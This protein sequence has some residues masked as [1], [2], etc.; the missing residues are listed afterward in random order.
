M[1]MLETSANTFLPYRFAIVR[2]RF[3]ICSSIS[4][5]TATESAWEMISSPCSSI[6]PAITEVSG[7][8]EMEATTSPLLSKTA[9]QVPIPS[10]ET[11]VYF[12]LTRCLLSFSI[13]S[14]PTPSALTEVTKV[15][16]SSTFP[17]SSATF[18]LTP[19]CTC[20]TR[21]AFR[22]PGM[23]LAAGYPLMSTKTVPIIT[24]PFFIFAFSSY[25]LQKASMARIR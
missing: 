22:P 3:R 12:M 5:S 19:P 2:T 9:S 23:Y 1:L 7:R 17:I 20:T 4:T 14:R 24:M 6:I 18:R 15:G 25:S 10:G 21:P 16:R 11:R 13:T 8:L